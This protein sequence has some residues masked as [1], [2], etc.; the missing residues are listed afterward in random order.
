[1]FQLRADRPNCLAVTNSVS[2]LLSL[3]PP[4]VFR[5]LETLKR[6]LFFSGTRIGAVSELAV[7][8]RALVLN[9]FFLGSKFVFVGLKDMIQILRKQLSE[10]SLIALT[11]IK[12]D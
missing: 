5:E 12:Y 3:R 2:S 6:S 8:N 7:T 1:M 11:N 4:R 9:F 10:D